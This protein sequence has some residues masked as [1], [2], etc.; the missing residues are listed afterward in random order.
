MYNLFDFNYR[1][2][3]ERV[4]EGQ[5][6]SSR[7]LGQRVR[8]I[9][10]WERE[11]SSELDR[12]IIGNNKMQECMRTLQRAILDVEIPQHISQE[13]LYHR[14]S[15]RGK[16]EIRITVN[17]RILPQFPVI[18]GGLRSKYGNLPPFLSFFP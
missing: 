4:Q 1:E 6:D 5:R 10:F 16:V 17:F 8:E 13:C 2:A 3:D 18:Y 14:E 11:L 9:S 7:M 12:I 15:R